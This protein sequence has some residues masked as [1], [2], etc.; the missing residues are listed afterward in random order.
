ML[1]LSALGIDML[2]G[3]IIVLSMLLLLTSLLRRALENKTSSSSAFTLLRHQIEG[4]GSSS[5]ATA[6]KRVS[7]RRNRNRSSMK[8]VQCSLPPS[9]SR[10]DEDNVGKV[11]VEANAGFAACVL[12]ATC[13]CDSGTIDYDA[14]RPACSPP[15][16]SGLEARHPRGIAEG[17]AE[18]VAEDGQDV[19]ASELAALGRT[20][21][22][23]GQ[24]DQGM[25]HGPFSEAA[26]C[27]CDDGGMWGC[28]C[29]AIYGK[30]L[31]L[32]HLAIN[33][34]IAQGAP[35][36]QRQHQ[37]PSR[38]ILPSTAAL[39]SVSAAQVRSA[40]FR[41]VDTHETPSR[42]SLAPR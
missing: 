39:P 1:Q 14:L 33:R 21:V 13:D 34:R 37:S 18:E 29:H 5:A 19:H 26:G 36:L 40:K 12:G 42:A 32:A 28:E 16:A 20:G 10:I 27:T 23:I 25:V 6:R 22:E 8:S 15:V 30:G 9:A 2:S 38:V 24:A 4:T 35:G 11:D 3:V 17:I 7:R 31:L 41:G